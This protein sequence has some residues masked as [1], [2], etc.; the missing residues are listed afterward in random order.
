[1]DRREFLAT[2]SA[3]GGAVALAGCSMFSRSRPSA[4][5]R[6]IPRHAV[7]EILQFPPGTYP[8]KG[9]PFHVKQDGELVGGG[10]KGD[11]VWKLDA[12]T[13]AGSVTGRLTN[14]VVRGHNHRSKAGID[15]YP[16]STVEGFVWPEG[17]QRSQ[18]RAFY[19]PS[20]GR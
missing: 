10:S 19:T 17:G 8:W 15:L 18:D 6:D 4:T 3:V 12:G 9:Q 11:V 1:M 2:A 20:G 14:V 13:M 7:R 5:V 16:G